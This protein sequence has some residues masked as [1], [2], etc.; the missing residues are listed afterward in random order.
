MTLTPV[1]IA[2]FCLLIQPAF[3][4]A[5]DEAAP[6]LSRQEEPFILTPKPGPAP[7]INGPKIYGAHPGNPFL[8]RLPAQGGRPMTFSASKLPKGLHLDSNTGIITGT[9]PKRG[10]YKLGVL[11]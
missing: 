7:C 1:L 5:D 3:A 4:L 9:T 8:Y 6:D 2:A 10:E 11:T